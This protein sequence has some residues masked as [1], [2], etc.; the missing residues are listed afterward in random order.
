MTSLVL[1]EKL[2][3]PVTQNGEIWSCVLQEL[4]L[5]ES[6]G[7]IK[8]HRKAEVISCLHHPLKS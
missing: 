5:E 8:N 6:R 2:S 7:H 4:H 1:S 3:S